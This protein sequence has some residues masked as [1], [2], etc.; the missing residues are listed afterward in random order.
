MALA[1][2]LSMP[3]NETNSARVECW[4]QQKLKRWKW[5]KKR[6]R[7]AVQRSKSAAHITSLK[8]QMKTGWKNMRGIKKVWNIGKIKSA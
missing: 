5:Q 2:R 4:I 3:E 6:G 7:K 1:E 8:Q